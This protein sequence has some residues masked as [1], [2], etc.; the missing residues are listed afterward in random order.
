[1]SLLLLIVLYNDYSQLTTIKKRIRKNQFNNEAR[2]TI[3]LL[4]LIVHYVDYDKLT[5]MNENY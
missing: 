3:S 4:L 1:M 5:T 2:I